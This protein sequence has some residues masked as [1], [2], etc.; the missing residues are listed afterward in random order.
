MAKRGPEDRSLSWWT[1]GGFSFWRDYVEG[2]KPYLTVPAKPIK[3]VWPF[4]QPGYLLSTLFSLAVGGP[5]A[6]D[7]AAGTFPVDMLIDWIRVW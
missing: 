2:A 7:P 1:A 4:N 6:G 5:G 3:G